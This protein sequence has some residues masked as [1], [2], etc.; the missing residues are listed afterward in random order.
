MTNSSLCSGMAECL[1]MGDGYQ[2][3]V[4]LQDIKTIVQLNQEAV[5]DILRSSTRDPELKIVTMGQLTDMSGTNDAFNSS[6]CS[7]EVTASLADK[8]E[9][10]EDE[11]TNK[12]ADKPNGNVASNGDAGVLGQKHR[13]FHFVIKSPPKASFIKMMHKM[14]KP[15]L[16]EVTWYL[17]LLRQVSLAESCLPSPLNSP[18]LSLT[19]QCPVVYHAHSNYYSGEVANSCAGCPWFCWLPIRAAEEGILVMENVKKRGFVM[20]DKMRI[21]PLDHFLL[22]MTNLAHF[23]GRWLA[24]R[25]M[26]EQEQLG[27]EAWSL[28]QFKSALD[29]QKRPPQFVYKQLLNGTAKT[30]RR[31]LE[32]EGKE[33][34]IPNV[35]H[36]FSVTA[37]R[38]LDR[39]MG[40]VTS[41]I[42]TCCHGDFWSNNIMFKYG[43]DGKVSGTILVDFQ[44]INYGHPAYDLMYLLY[45]STDTQFR[46]HHME[47]CLQH[48]WATLNQ[49]ITQLAPKGFKYE[50]TDFQADV[51]TYKTI[52]FV[53]ATTLLPNVLSTTQLEPGGLLALKE[54]QRKQAAELE[55]GDNIASKEIKRRI[56][57]LTEEL[58]RDN[59]I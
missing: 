54:M 21:L 43:E 5:R 58:V 9:N 22:A 32:L 27:S 8:H 26:S 34:L 33:D 30:V 31:I 1:A 14:T 38:Q 47:Q 42:D 23:H 56:V 18:D 49:Y 39:F 25:W 7:L 46:D 28:E 17:D 45:L 29:T 40:N 55:D 2:P 48:Y 37:R 41:L 59:V 50:W 44:L 52:G 24:Y 10:N 11:T 6:I 12:E 51:Q 3:L 19:N 13:T 16:N 4:G 53:L 36:F 57:G 20:F 15:F 35:R